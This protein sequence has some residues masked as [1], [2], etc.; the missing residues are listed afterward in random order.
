MSDPLPRVVLLPKR[1]RPVDG[2][3]PWVFAGAVGS[4]EGDPGDGDEVDL[5]T[6]TGLFVARG[7][8]NSQSNI[9]VRLLAWDADTRL[10]AAFFR[11]RILSAVGL[12]DRLGLNDPGTG[13]RLVF[14]EGDGLSGLI[15]DR[16][17]RWLV[18]QFTS[19]GMALR[20]DLIA[21]IL[22]EIVRPEGIYLRTEKGV[23]Q[24]E[25]L[26]LVDGPLSGEPPAGP[27]A[28]EEHGLKILVNLAE[29]Q[30]TGY[31]LDQRDN[32]QEVARLSGGRRVLDAF[33]YT[34]G[35][36]LHAARAGASEVIGVDG[37]APALALAEENAR[38]NDLRTIT[39]HKADVFDDLAQRVERGERFGVVVLDPPK[40]ARSRNAI[41]QALDG[42]NR[43]QTM[44]LRLL[45]PDGILA[46]C[47]CSGLITREMLE[48][49]LANV[50]ALMGR[51]VQLLQ[52]RGP[53]PDHPVSVGCLETHYLKCLLARVV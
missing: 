39:F 25:G 48:G 37:S 49:Q 2:R 26:P 52:V 44:A 31:Y 16:Y 33:C 17:A 8:F 38:R 34:G 45:E 3:H 9:R 19:L 14:S 50:A 6:N 51:D 12:R 36:G 46:T 41:D 18:V 5:V 29:G 4:V 32:R 27:I 7:L 23:G 35:F 42:Y 21:G 43:L 11:A 10:D 24:L 40:F 47:C 28:I 13:C 53:S 15:V 1:A 20:R 30:K 22:H